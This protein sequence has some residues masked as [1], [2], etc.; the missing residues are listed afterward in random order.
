MSTTLKKHPSVDVVAPVETP[1]EG[2]VQHVTLGYDNQLRKARSTWSI[3]S[4]IINIVAVPFGIGG[5]LISALY[6][7]GQRA[8]FAGLFVVLFFDGCV[9]VSLA[10]L[11][12]RYPT[13]SGVYYWSYRLCGEHKRTRK[14]LSF[15]TGWAW[16][17]G[18][19]T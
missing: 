9:A 13:S 5:P 1:R 8:L 18:N 7:G 10:E 19:W 3:L 15:M 4:M 12:S 6:G 2:V 17:I 16:L 11:A 14:I